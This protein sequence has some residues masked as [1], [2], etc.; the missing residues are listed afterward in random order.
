VLKPDRLMDHG[1]ITGL[2]RPQKESN[3]IA[4]LLELLV[5]ALLDIFWAIYAKTCELTGRYLLKLVGV[6]NPSDKAIGMMTLAV[7]LTVLITVVWY[8]GSSNHSSA[9]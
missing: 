8:L 2:S 7:S 6:N 3:T 1:S 4:Q 5:Q 9:R